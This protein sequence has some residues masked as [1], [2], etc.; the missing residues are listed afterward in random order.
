MSRCL[1]ISVL[2]FLVFSSEGVEGF[3]NCPSKEYVCVDE[4]HYQDCWYFLFF[5]KFGSEVSCPDGQ[6]CN[7]ETEGEKCISLTT[8]TLAP[9]TTTKRTC[10]S[11]EFICRNETAY[12]TCFWF[13]YVDFYRNPVLCDDGYICDTSPDATE[14]CIKQETTTTAP[15]TVAPTTDKPIYCWI[16]FFLC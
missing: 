6:I 9:T 2:I 14:F 3:R 1:L 5:A 16:L 12:Q 4:T 11:K 7:E 10:P 8:T 15:T 13:M